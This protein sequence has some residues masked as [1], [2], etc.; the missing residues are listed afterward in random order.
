MEV[1][2]ETINGLTINRTD[3]EMSWRLVHDG[4]KV[5]DLFESSGV[6][7]TMNTIYLASSIEE[8]QAQI[9]SLSL[10]YNS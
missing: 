7:S 6:T 3:S 10:E 2:Q 4:S 5:I 1:T 9:Y 8:C